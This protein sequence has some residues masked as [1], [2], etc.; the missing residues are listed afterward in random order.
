ML[1]LPTHF[2][3][4]ACLVYGEGRKD[5]KFLIVL[6]DLPKFRYHTSMWRFNY[7]NSSGSSP[8]NV[9]EQCRKEL[10]GYS[11]DLVLCFIDLDKLK[12]DFPKKWKSKRLEYER[13]YLN[14]NIEIIWQIDKLEDEL[15]KVL[16]YKSAKKKEINKLAQKG[17][18]K[19]INSDFW[20][21]I[22]KSIKQKEKLLKQ[23][24]DS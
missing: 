9:L 6:I 4:Y 23:Q 13:R 14:Y 20:K 15:K 11:Y 8:R 16:G 17:I 1:L 22:L 19:F 12:T 21:R 3:N 7:G 18:E 10:E 24:S 2:F 5:K